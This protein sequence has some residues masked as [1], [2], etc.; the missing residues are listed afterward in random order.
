MWLFGGGGGMFV[1]WTKASWFVFCGG[2]V[3]NLRMLPIVTAELG[4][5]INKQ[6][7]KSWLLSRAELAEML[8]SAWE[9][10][11]EEGLFCITYVCYSSYYVGEI[12]SKCTN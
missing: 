3:F 2:G 5:S 6:K 10:I 7:N 9:K 8:K 1:V 11:R 12:N 4:S